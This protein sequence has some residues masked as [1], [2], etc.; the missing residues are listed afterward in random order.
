MLIRYLRELG[1]AVKSLWGPPTF[2]DGYFWAME[3]LRNG[4]ISVYDLNTSL[5]DLEPFDQG[6]RQAMFDWKR[7]GSPRNG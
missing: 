4:S 7:A 3:A 2:Q 6:I 5:D 1:R